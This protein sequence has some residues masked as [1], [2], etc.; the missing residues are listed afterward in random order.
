MTNSTV[1]EHEHNDKHN[2]LHKGEEQKDGYGHPTKDS[3]PPE[4]D[5]SKGKDKFGYH[6]LAKNVNSTDSAL[7]KKPTKQNTTAPAV[8]KAEVPMKEPNR[9]AI[10]LTGAH[11]ARELITLQMT[12]YQIL[13]LIH[14][15]FI[16]QQ[17]KY[18]NLLA[19]NKYY[20]IPVVNPDGVAF[21]ETE[22]GKN[23]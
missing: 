14:A 13:K 9:P 21:I 8:K 20:V 10:L 1:N 2:E 17:P 11:H 16:T 19:Q 7:S 15:G 4:N 12:L 3:K 6:T 5:K 22:F 23:R 18:R